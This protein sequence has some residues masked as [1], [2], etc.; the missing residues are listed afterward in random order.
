MDS[1]TH[2]K[3]GERIMVVGDNHGDYADTKACRAALAF[4]KYFKPKWRVHLGDCFDLRW[5]RGSA[6]DDEKRSG[7]GDDI[8][9]GLDFLQ[10]YKPTHFLMGNHELRIHRAMDSTNARV[11]ELACLLWGQVMGHLDGVKTLPYCK[12]KGVLRIGDHAFLHGYSSGMYAVKKTGMAYGNAVMGHVH[13]PETFRIERHEGPTAHCVG[14]LCKIDMDYNLTQQAT[15]AQAHGF[16]YGFVI[17]GKVKL[18]HATKMGNQWI[19]P[20]EMMTYGK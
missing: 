9:D 12:R 2:L 14:C 19:F 6:S 1:I 3:R 4:A 5:L 20:T 16:M 10:Q 13:R 11:S 18:W 17:G 7:S 8:A 15:L